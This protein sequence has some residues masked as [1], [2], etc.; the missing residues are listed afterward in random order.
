MCACMSYMSYFIVVFLY[1]RRIYIYIYNI[2]VNR[3]TNSPKPMEMRSHMDKIFK[4]LRLLLLHSLSIQ[5]LL[6]PFCVLLTFVFVCF[7]LSLSPIC[8]RFLLLDY[9]FKQNRFHLND[10]YFIL[11]LDFVVRCFLLLWLLPPMIL[12]L[13][14]LFSLPVVTTMLFRFVEAGK[15]GTNKTVSFL[16][17]HGEFVCVWFFRPHRIAISIYFYNKYCVLFTLFHIPLNTHG[18]IVCTF[19]ALSMQTIA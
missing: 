1:V 14:Y 6:L 9:V 12:L 16:S 15:K 17:S 5:C 3:Q 2:K 7:F 13:A 10:V 11:Q 18:N 19:S 8:Y 4:Y